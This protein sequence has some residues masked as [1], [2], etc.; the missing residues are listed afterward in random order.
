MDGS[1][2]TCHARARLME[3][4]GGDEGQIRGDY[5]NPTASQ[6]MD[7]KAGFMTVSHGLCMMLW[8]RGLVRGM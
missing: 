6:S 1:C 7:G 4:N 5:T 2:I 8:T 3:G